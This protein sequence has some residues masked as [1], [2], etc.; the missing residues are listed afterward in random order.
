MPEEKLS[1]ERAKKLIAEIAELRPGWVIIEGGEPLLRENLFELPGLIQQRQ[2]KVHLITN[3]MVEVPLAPV[4][5][6][7]L[8]LAIK[9]EQDENFRH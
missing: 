1:T 5:P 2:L 7:S 9:K 4:F 8:K 3:G 6:L